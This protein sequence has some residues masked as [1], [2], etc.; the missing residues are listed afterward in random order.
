MSKRFADKP[1]IVTKCAGREPNEDIT[2]KQLMGAIAL[3]AFLFFISTLCLLGLEKLVIHLNNGSKMPV[4]INHP[5][6]TQSYYGK[7]LVIIPTSTLLNESIKCIETNQSSNILLNNIIYSHLQ[8]RQKII[9]YFGVFYDYSR[10]K[11]G[12]LAVFG[13]FPLYVTCTYDLRTMTDFTE[14]SVP[15]IPL[16][17]QPRYETIFMLGSVNEH[18]IINYLEQG[19]NLQNSVWLVQ[20]C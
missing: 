6:F 5:N 8:R 19:A 13:F 11:R 17:N 20:T 12:Q 14:N 18:N 9:E 16:L 1:G 7:E 10:F 3:F 15:S 4:Y 2:F